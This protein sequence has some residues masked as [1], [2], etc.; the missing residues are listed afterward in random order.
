EQGDAMK[1]KGYGLKGRTH[2][3]LFSWQMRDTILLVTI[4]LVFLSILIIQVNHGYDFQFYPT[5][6]NVPITL[7]EIGRTLLVLGFVS[8]LSLVEIKEYLQWQFA[9]SKI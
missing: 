6:S 3:S 7:P 9:K 8:L 5:V 4:G 2:F 1:A